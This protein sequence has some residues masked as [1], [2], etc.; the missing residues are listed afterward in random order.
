V[1]VV[2]VTIVV[3]VCSTGTGAGSARSLL[4]WA[5]SVVGVVVVVGGVG[6]GVGGV[7]AHQ[8]GAC[9]GC[10]TFR[11]SRTTGWNTGTNTLVA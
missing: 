2:W 1:I 11:R 3:W 7:G 6:V 10:W 9:S 8:S 4:H 5:F